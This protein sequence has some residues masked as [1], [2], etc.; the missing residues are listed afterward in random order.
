MFVVSKR[1]K[2][3]I[4]L[5]DLE[6]FSDEEDDWNPTDDEILDDLFSCVECDY[7]TRHEKTF[8]QHM[9]KHM[10]KSNPKRK[11]VPEKSSTSKQIKQTDSSSLTC[12]TCGQTFSRKDSLKRHIVRKH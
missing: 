11:T 9:T 5:R 6:N 3:N 12:E 10:K 4:N 8:K 1:I 2:Q 7:T